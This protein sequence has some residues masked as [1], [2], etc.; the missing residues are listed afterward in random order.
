MKRL[1]MIV[2]LGLLVPAAEAGAQ[3]FKAGATIEMTFSTDSL[4]PTLY[5]MMRGQQVA[6][7]LTFRLPDDFDSSKTYPLLVYVPGFDGGPKGNIGNAETIAG[8]LGW[9]VATVPLFKKT[10]DKDETGGGLIVSVEDAPVV[11]QAYRVMLGKF[12]TTVPHIDRERSAMV[13]FSNG[14]QTIA[15]LV[16]F[17]DEFFFDHF[18]NFCLVDHGM[19][20]LTDLHKKGARECRYLVL[21]G[22]KP[23]YGRELKIRGSQLL[24]DEMHTLGVNLR[25]EIMKDTGHEFNPKQMEIVHRWLMGN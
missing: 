22:D 1:L 20:H 7:V 4:P 18:R 17:H 24:Q 2:Y 16:S 14:A 25:S 21:V 19:F 10:V 12:F 5:S 23:D 11:A 9:I 8:S 13:G 6:P 3:E 15:V